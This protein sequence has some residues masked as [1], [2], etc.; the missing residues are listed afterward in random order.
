MRVEIRWPDESASHPNPPRDQIP[1]RYLCRRDM[2]N[3]VL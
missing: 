1:S 3:G 2:A